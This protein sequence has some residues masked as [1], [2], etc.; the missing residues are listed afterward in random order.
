V[1]EGQERAVEAAESSS[2]APEKENVGVEAVDY[3]QK[4]DGLEVAQMK[5][6]I[7]RTKGV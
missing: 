7:G 4:M 5:D 2:C 1:P 3:D 6:E